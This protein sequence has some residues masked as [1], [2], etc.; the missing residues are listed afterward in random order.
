MDEKA[1]IERL[2]RWGQWARSGSRKKQTSS[3]WLVMRENTPHASQMPDV[4]AE[5]CLET[6]RLLVEVCGGAD[7]EMVRARF[8][9]GRSL[10]WIEEH[11]RYSRNEYHKRMR[12]ILNAI[13]KRAKISIITPN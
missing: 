3:L 10:K 2:R 1:W 13:D 6:D 4:S 9:H 7:L 8:V 12:N 11:L 5:E